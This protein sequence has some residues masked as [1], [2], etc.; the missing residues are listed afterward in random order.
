MGQ[1]ISLHI[2]F[3]RN[4]PLYYGG[5]LLKGVVRV[6]PADAQLHTKQVVLKI[7]GQAIGET[8]VERT[9]FLGDRY[10]ASDVV[11][12]IFFQDLIVLAKPP[13][14]EKKLLVC[15]GSNTWSFEIKL[16]TN[17]PPTFALPQNIYQNH[18]V[19]HFKVEANIEKTFSDLIDRKYIIFRP[20]VTI[21]SPTL[22]SWTKV[23]LISACYSDY[24]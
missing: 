20:L 8:I 6:S 11:P 5:E 3:E 23:R 4:L 12:Y 17:A 19:V 9:T 22:V 16:P 24:Y 2:D 10:S 15:K 7:E 1:P 18:P 13:P 14:G 21:E